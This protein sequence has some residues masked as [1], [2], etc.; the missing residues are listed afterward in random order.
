MVAVLPDKQEKL[1][2]YGLQFG[3][4]L[5][6]ARKGLAEIRTHWLV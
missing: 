1:A 2:N 3:F 4:H 5:F 6:C